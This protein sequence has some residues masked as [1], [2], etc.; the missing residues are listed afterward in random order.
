M[1]LCFAAGA[2]DVGALGQRETVQPTENATQQSET[3]A[4]TMTGDDANAMR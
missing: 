1:N 2:L 4:L 3:V